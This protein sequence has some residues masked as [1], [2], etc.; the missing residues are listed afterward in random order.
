M[1]L[2]RDSLYEGLEEVCKE[3]ILHYGQKHKDLKKEYNRNEELQKEKVA[4]KKVYLV[5]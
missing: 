4:K 5:D 3:T 2:D 1:L